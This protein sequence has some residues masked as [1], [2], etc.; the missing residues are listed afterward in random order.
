[1]TL[2]LRSSIRAYVDS[3]ISAVWDIAIASYNESL[4]LCE[5]R[6]ISHD[7]KD[8]W[9]AD[10]FILDRDDRT[11][12]ILAEDY[13]FGSNRAT[14]SKLV[15]DNASMKIADK[16]SLLELDTHLSFPFVFRNGPDLFVLPENGKSGRLTCYML[17][18]GRLIDPSVL[19]ESSV[20][21]AVLFEKDGIYFIFCTEQYRCNGNVVTV[22]CSDTLLGK[23]EKAY[24]I[25]LDDN[26][27]R[28]A[29][30]IFNICG[31]TVRPAQ[32]CNGDYGEAVCL[33]ALIPGADG[34]FSLK[35]IKRLTPLEGK[36]INGIHT[37]NVYDGDAGIAVIDGYHYNTDFFR[38]F[39]SEFLSIKESIRK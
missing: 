8:R 2:T 20:A 18:N 12:T 27:A 25:V 23:Y 30:T 1:M 17:Q 36:R 37:F 16:S 33:Q 13:V 24:E 26:T 15:V 7:W 29:G 35:E 32:V 9:F 22:L 5:V 6:W 28:S 38:K 11:T 14:I 10:P 3:R 39:Y 31:T 34:R 19:F 21:D 4:N